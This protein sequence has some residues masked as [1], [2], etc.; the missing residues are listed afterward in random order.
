MKKMLIILCFSQVLSACVMVTP[1]ISTSDAFWQEKGLSIGIVSSKPA[2]A[3]SHKRGPQGL[4]DVAINEAASGGLDTYL[5]SIDLSKSKSATDPYQRYLSKRGF[6]AAKLSGQLDI[7]SL[8]DFTKEEG[9]KGHFASKDFR[10]LK[11]K[12]NVDRLL[13]VSVEQIGTIRSYY[14]FIPTSAPAGICIIN[15]KIVN[16]DSNKL[17]WNHT[18]TQEV[19]YKSETW[20]EPPKYPGLTR[21]ILSALDRST[22][23]LFDEFAE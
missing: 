17:E 13:I 9:T 19:P 2:I 22:L 12:Y 21:A 15:G 8:E 4:L 5:K 6:K 10:P 7:S 14:G 18:I 16:L 20:R 23:R 1:D 3:K 11:S